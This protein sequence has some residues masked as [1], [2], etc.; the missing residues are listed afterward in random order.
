MGGKAFSHLDPPLETP[1]MP[2]ETY[3][4]VKNQLIRTLAP[5]FSWIDC[6]IEG[7]GKEDYGDVDL[8]VSGL[9]G[10]D[11]RKESILTLINQLLGAQAQITEPGSA[12]AAHFAIPWPKELPYPADYG[13]L[14]TDDSQ[15][16]NQSTR[17]LEAISPD[18]TSSSDVSRPQSGAHGTP[19]SNT[20]PLTL[21]EL[22]DKGNSIFPHASARQTALVLALD[23]GNSGGDQS[24]QANFSPRPDPGAL[25]ST[26][27]SSSK[28]SSTWSSRSKPKARLP[29]SPSFSS[30]SHLISK[31]GH[32]GG[33][34]TDGTGDKSKTEKTGSAMPDSISGPPAGLYIQVD[35]H[36][37]FD[38]KEAKYLRFHQ[39]HGDIWQLL[40]SIIKPFGLTVDNKGLWI[41]IPEVEVVDRKKAKILLTS[42]PNQI[43][44]FIGVPVPEYWRPFADVESTFQYVAKCNMFWVDPNYAIEQDLTAAKSNSRRRIS[45]RPVYQQWVTDFKPRC[46]E[47]GL[48]SKAPTTREEV[49]D[50]AFQTFKIETEYHERLRGFIFETQKT[51]IIKEIK[52]IFPAVAQPTNQKAVQMRSLHIKAMREIIIEQVDEWRYNIVAPDG[53]RQPN[54]LFNMDRV[55][56][57]ARSIADEVAAAVAAGPS[58]GRPAAGGGSSIRVPSAPRAR[59]RSFGGPASNS[60]SA[61]G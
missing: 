20:E 38:V 60:R 34:A 37:C 2:K 28:K 7:P 30:L 44:D 17:P 50:K 19:D 5:A 26:P 41:R 3:L 56:T 61:T 29:R 59:R 57:Y 52:A 43:L 16:L 58:R 10:S 24:S 25:P 33:N 55:R 4:V 46:R 45:N 15:E 22:R 14:P 35:V 21:K 48:Y 42:V 51:D 53:L 11:M 6:P 18:Y 47:Q 36:F 49:R 32:P 8:I 39:A 23:G 31:L 54:G 40:G 9:V 1:R 27:T 12:V 13:T